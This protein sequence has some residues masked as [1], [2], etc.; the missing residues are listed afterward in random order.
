MEQRY[1]RNRRNQPEFLN[2]LQQ[3]PP[4]QPVALRFHIRGESQ[5]LADRVAATMSLQSNPPYGLGVNFVRRGDAGLE[6]YDLWAQSADA[7]SFYSG[8]LL[9]ALTEVGFNASALEVT[10]LDGIHSFDI[11]GERHF[12]EQPDSSQH[13]TGGL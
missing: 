8:R 3:L 13:Y 9:P 1:E 10:V 4:D 6:V 11:A 5:E 12:R 2:T 7:V